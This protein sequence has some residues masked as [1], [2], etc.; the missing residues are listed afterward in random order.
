[1]YENSTFKKVIWEA[2]T[3]DECRS[4]VSGG[5]SGFKFN[6]NQKKKLYL[7]K[8]KPIEEISKWP[9]DMP[10]PAWANV[11]KKFDGFLSEHDLDT[12]IVEENL[13][14]SHI[15]SPWVDF[16]HKQLLDLYDVSD[17][18]ERA[19]ESAKSWLSRE[20]FQICSDTLLTE[21]EVYRKINF[22]TSM[23]SNYDGSH[24]SYIYDKFV[25]EFI[26]EGMYL[27][28]FESYPFLTRF[29]FSRLCDWVRNMGAFC[30]RYKNDSIDLEN[31]IGPNCG[32]IHDLSFPDQ[33]T[34]NGGKTPIFIHFSPES[35][36]PD[37]VYKPRDMSAEVFYYEIVRYAS[38]LTN[39]CL[40]TPNVVSKDSH[41]WVEYVPTEYVD[42]SESPDGYFEKIGIL[43]G[44][45]HILCINDCHFENVSHG[46]LSSVLIDAETIF[47]PRIS[48]NKTSENLVD[49]VLWSGWLPI[50]LSNSDK[51]SIDISGIRFKKDSDAKST[52]DRWENINSDA[53]H[54]NES[55]DAHTLSISDDNSNLS[56]D[57]QNKIISGFSKCVN[58]AGKIWVKIYNKAGFDLCHRVIFRAT[59]TYS[60]L[61]HKMLKPK[62]LSN[63]KRMSK[64]LSNL[65]ESP[66]DEDEPNDIQIGLI[67]HEKKALLRQDIPRFTSDL[68]I[69]NSKDDKKRI[70][71][72][73]NLTASTFNINIDK[74]EALYNIEKQTD[75]IEFSCRPRDV[76]R[77][78]HEFTNSFLEK[79]QTHQQDHINRRI[80]LEIAKNSCEYI[81]DDSNLLF[82]ATSED[83]LSIEPIHNGFYYG[84]LGVA[85]YI[86]EIIDTLDV[87]D[88]GE[89]RKCVNFIVSDVKDEIIQNTNNNNLSISELTQYLYSLSVIQ[90]NVNPDTEIKNVI[91][92]MVESIDHE[93]L[94]N[95]SMYDLISGTAGLIQAIIKSMP[96]LED[97]ILKNKLFLCYDYLLKNRTMTDYGYQA[98]KNPLGTKPLL[99]LSHGAAGISYALYNAYSITHD[100]RLIR[101]VRESL[102]YEECVY[103]DND[104]WKNFRK[105]TQTDSLSI[106]YGQIGSSLVCE[107]MSG[108]DECN[109]DIHNKFSINFNELINK[110]KSYNYLMGLS[111]MAVIGTSSDVFALKEYP[112]RTGEIISTYIINKYANGYV[113]L[114]RH[115]N[116]I[117]NSSL[118]EG[119]PGI[120]HMILK[121]RVNRDLSTHL[122]LS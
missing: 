104:G 56:L 66:L 22:P 110:K 88:N 61:N 60:L 18:S 116:E 82:T 90:S 73:N 32:V 54:K 100:D 101:A 119:E 41:G 13:P 38:E 45:S 48:N 84:Q 70:I 85:T 113:K 59:S 16:S 42:K 120:G 102:N 49:T 28:V 57:E 50:D 26:N 21:F 40:Q 53:M 96:Y 10:I 62:N 19:I 121:T 117:Y 33:E 23:S 63:K 95:D 118:F 74:I 4:L 106:P 39:I 87:R 89:L 35:S 98:W 29:I 122:L 75:L 92:I 17:L 107:K 9:N 77:K 31:M 97:S 105:G 5:G 52:E 24:S 103:D 15:I 20:L 78:E 55:H 65:S 112:N 68:S 30:S 43:I 47:H 86:S 71:I 44:L 80:I 1:M 115:S 111:G 83:L 67:E 93:L 91:N 27:E 51:Y 81:N 58:Q 94:Q 64:I 36:S 11:W 7:D 46:S 99:G 6:C 109:M 8:N 14:F 2:H 3:K 37:L 25:N 114:P 34:H 76:I 69:C 72:K 108:I 12:N 79:D